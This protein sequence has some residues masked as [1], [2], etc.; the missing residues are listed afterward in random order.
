ML[1]KDCTYGA[2]NKSFNFYKAVTP[3]GEKKG[4]C[5]CSMHLLCGQTP[6]RL[7]ALASQTPPKGGNKKSR[8]IT[9]PLLTKRQ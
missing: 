1:I 5:L 8:G 2:K 3:N 7:C 4:G 9:Y 6:P